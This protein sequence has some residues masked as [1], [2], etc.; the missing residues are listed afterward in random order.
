MGGAGGGVSGSTA[1]VG[2]DVSAPPQVNALCQMAQPESALAI[3]PAA[4]RVRPV[5]KG[6]GAKG[7]WGTEDMGL[8]LSR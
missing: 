4:N 6:W 3:R 2:V 1:A 8:L 5:R 7:K